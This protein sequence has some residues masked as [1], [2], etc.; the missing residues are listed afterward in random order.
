[1]I[2][3]SY[4]MALIRKEFFSYFYTPIGY[5]FL[6]IFLLLMNFLFFVIA[7][8][9]DLGFSTIDDYFRMLR[10]AYIFF[11]PAITMRLWAEEKRS[12]TIEILF[13]LP[14][15]EM[16]LILGKY[17][18][19]LLFLGIALLLTLFVPISIGILAPLDP[20][21]I[22][23]SYLGAFFLG[24]SYIALGEYISW[25]TKDQISAFLITMAFAFLFFIMGYS[26]I[27]QY[28]GPLK[29][30]VAFLS[31]SWHY[32]SIARGLLD[33][34]DFIYFLSFSALFLYL[35]YRSIQEVR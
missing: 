30:M 10:F 25:K 16:E 22:I 28:L 32:D 12:G 26:P 34:R 15:R 2:R 21:L 5:I 27:L 31:L 11:I 9:W 4:L 35:Q 33:T 20:N 23:G 29:E 24:A 6:A 3:M 17:I 19:A 1:M 13:T 14:Y 18:S 7:K 8:F